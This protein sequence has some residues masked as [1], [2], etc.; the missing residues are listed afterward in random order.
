VLS[1]FE[2]YL[3]FYGLLL[4]LSVAEVA[5]GF[6]NAIDARQ[7]IR[8]GWLTPILAIFVFFDITSFWIYV[9][10]IRDDV[11]VNWGTMFGALVIALTYYIAA[12]LI[13][14]R[15][16]GDW[17]DLNKHYWRNK[18]FILAGIITANFIIGTATQAIHPPVQD[19]S[20]W[21]GWA[22]YWPPLLVLGFSR[23]GRFDLVLLFILIAGYLANIFLPTSWILT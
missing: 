21:V 1:A 16:E 12:G 23:S 6:R 14:P 7:K 2:F 11:I 5:S 9:W 19:W 8:I 3:S 20:Y 10:G 4:G 22:S 13:F 18:R 17:P 15:D